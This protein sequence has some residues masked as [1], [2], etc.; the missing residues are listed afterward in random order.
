MI[1][2]AAQM[3]GAILVVSAATG[4]MPQ[5]REHILLARQVGVPN[6]V[7]YLN[8]VRFEFALCYGRSMRRPWHSYDMLDRVRQIDQ[9]TDPELADLVEMEV[10]ELLTS[11][12]FPGDKTPVIRGSALAALEGRDPEIGVKSL[13]KLLEAIDT[14]VCASACGGLRLCLCDWLLWSASHMDIRY[15][16][17]PKRALDKPFLMPIE[18]IVTIPG[19]GTV[20]TGAV[21]QGVVKVTMCFSIAP[22]ALYLSISLFFSPTFMYVPYVIL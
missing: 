17:E 13:E 2:G 4:V 9:V 6:I 11:Y 14:Y 3:D 10:R 1:A 19:R 18:G 12:G 5:T 16:P 22:Y 21:E 7:V 15:F 20:V 8:K